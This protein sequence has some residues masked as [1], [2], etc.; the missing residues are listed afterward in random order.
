MSKNTNNLAAYGQNQP[1]IG[2]F[3]P[4]IVSKGAKMPGGNDKAEIGRLW[5]NKTTNQVWALTSFVGGLA[6]W[7][8]LDDAGATGITWVTTAAPGVAAAINHGYVLSHV[9]TQ[10]VTLP[11]VAVVGSE[12]Y[13]ETLNA[14]DGDAGVTMVVQ[15]AAGDLITQDN[16]TSAA[17]GTLTFT[18][19]GA[20]RHSVHLIC[21]DANTQWRVISASRVGN[22]A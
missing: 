4:P 22:F 9:A 16:A 2:I 11:A 7:T 19:H 1:L 20:A 13:M 8:P 3:N 21:I 12:I 17:G 5:V 14:I 6:V 10:T 15:A 18:S